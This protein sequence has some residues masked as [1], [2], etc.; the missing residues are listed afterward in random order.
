MGQVTTS[1]EGVRARFHTDPTDVTQLQRL[2]MVSGQ[3]GTRRSS[4]LDLLKE[5]CPE[6]Q[7]HE[8]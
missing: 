3:P 1:V 2:V 8:I 4:K 6:L 5:P 7:E